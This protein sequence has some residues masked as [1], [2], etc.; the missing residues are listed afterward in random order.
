MRL[1]DFGDGLAAT[2]LRSSLSLGLGSA[3]WRLLMVVAGC[4]WVG[5]SG[6]FARSVLTG[7]AERGNDESR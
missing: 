7:N 2:S 6:C 4:E 3:R 1:V 5:I